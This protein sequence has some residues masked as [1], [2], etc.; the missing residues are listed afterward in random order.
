MGMRDFTVTVVDKQGNPL[1]N[2]V[3]I[4]GQPD[5]FFNPRHV[6]SDKNG[7]AVIKI[8]KGVRGEWKLAVVHQVSPTMQIYFE[9]NDHLAAMKCTILDGHTT[10][11]DINIDCGIIY[12]ND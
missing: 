5:N 11:V 2:A 9:M 4:S 8:P 6:F 1:P 3:V 12:N 10:E 7:I